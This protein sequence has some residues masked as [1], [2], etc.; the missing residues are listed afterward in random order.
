[1]A[2]LGSGTVAFFHTVREKAQTPEAIQMHTRAKQLGLT[3]IALGFVATV[4][5]GISHW[6]LPMAVKHFIGNVAV[7]GW[8]GVALV[9]AATL[10]ALVIFHRTSYLGRPNQ[11]YCQPTEMF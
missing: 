10:E 3:L 4:L 11:E 8:N 6:C 1:M 2:S 7:M 5:A 9:F